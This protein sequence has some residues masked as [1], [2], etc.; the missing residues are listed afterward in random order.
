[1]ASVLYLLCVVTVIQLTS[2]QS[3]WD[4]DRQQNDVSSCGSS[5]EQALKQL[6]TMNAQLV[7]ANA[8]LINAVSQLQRDV[9][10]LQTGSPQ[11]DA[12]GKSVGPKGQAKWNHQRSNVAFCNVM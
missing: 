11:E 4:I 8:Q 2:S 7:T 5:S 12:T 3:T 10:E 1:M 6:M 9:A